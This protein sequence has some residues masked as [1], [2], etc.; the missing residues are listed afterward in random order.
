MQGQIAWVWRL[1]SP[2]TVQSLLMSIIALEDKGSGSIS[3][4]ST[5]SLLT[6][7]WKDTMKEELW[8]AVAAVTSPFGINRSEKRIGCWT[9][10]EGTECA[11]RLP[12]TAQAQPATMPRQS[13]AG[14]QLQ[15][16]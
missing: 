15:S 3:C 13:Q 4:R 6:L 9:S 10:L 8:A 14:N 1:L 12:L 11:Q 5:F 16:R 2:G 7:V